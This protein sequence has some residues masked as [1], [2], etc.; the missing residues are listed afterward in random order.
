ML[1]RKVDLKSILMNEKITRL[2]F[3]SLSVYPRYV[4]NI[5]H[6]D[7]SSFLS[8]SCRKIN[9]FS[10]QLLLHSEH[11]FSHFVAYIDAG[12]RNQMSV[13]NCSGQAEATGA[14]SNLMRLWGLRNWSPG[15]LTFCFYYITGI[16]HTHIVQ[17]IEYWVHSQY[18]LYSSPFPGLGTRWVIL[19][20]WEK[21]FIIFL[22]FWPFLIFQLQ[23]VL[24]V[25]CFWAEKNL[26]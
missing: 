18:I 19:T 26:V 4:H 14:S 21:I 6:R 23:D 8:T 5:K 25:R 1:I 22:I 16:R 11:N 3:S 10:N 15:N 9:P 7:F 24:G 17:Y 12:T 20:S 13:T 2:N